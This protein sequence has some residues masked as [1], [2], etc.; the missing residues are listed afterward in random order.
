M[1]AP[2]LKVAAFKA[3]ESKLTAGEGGSVTGD[4][5]TASEPI[6]KSLSAFGAVV[7]S[8]APGS[9]GRASAARAQIRRMGAVR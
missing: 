3:L 4:Q 9:L 2:F 8:T 6:Q 5:A 1:P 7:S